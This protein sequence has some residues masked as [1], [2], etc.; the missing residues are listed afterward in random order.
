M[1]RK[2]HFTAD[3]TLPLPPAPLFCTSTEPSSS[4]Q[5]TYYYQ[6]YLANSCHDFPVLPFWARRCTPPKRPFYRMWRPLGSGMGFCISLFLSALSWESEFRMLFYSFSHSP[7]T[8][9]P[10]PAF[11]SSRYRRLEF[12]LRLDFVVDAAKFGSIRDHGFMLAILSSHLAEK[13]CG[14]HG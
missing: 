11:P 2:L 7:E 1:P 10:R 14:I 13:P 8:T 5:G 12:S 6:L 9:S 4:I 3:D